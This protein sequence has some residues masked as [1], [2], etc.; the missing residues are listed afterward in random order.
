MRWK[1]EIDVHS[2][3]ISVEVEDILFEIRYFVHSSK[4]SSTCS[5]K[6]IE[7]I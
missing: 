1:G 2:Y 6:G 5:K 4:F 3:Y 7:R